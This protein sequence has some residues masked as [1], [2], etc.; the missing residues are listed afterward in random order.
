MLEHQTG[1]SDQY[2]R[3]VVKKVVH[4]ATSRSEKYSMVKVTFMILTP[5]YAGKEVAKYYC[6]KAESRDASYWAVKQGIADL[7][8]LFS[9]ASKPPG[10]NPISLANCIVMIRLESKPSKRGESWITVADVKAAQPT[11]P[12]DN[13]PKDDLPF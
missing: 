8:K 11:A 10:S 12:V 5:G 9:A 6:I 13:T 7:A 4:G 1:S 3:A 2:H